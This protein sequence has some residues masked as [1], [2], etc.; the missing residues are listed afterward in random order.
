MI[1][2]VHS[3][4]SSVYNLSHYRSTEFFFRKITL[5]LPCVSSLLENLIF[6][7]NDMKSA[8]VNRAHYP[9]KPG[10]P[11]NEKFKS[12]AKKAFGE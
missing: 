12:M 5:S 10:S 3:I 9:R 2:Y 6:I 1:T 7:I 4:C 8:I 11:L